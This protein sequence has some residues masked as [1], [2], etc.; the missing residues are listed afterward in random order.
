MALLTLQHMVYT[1]CVFYTSIDLK[2]W[3]RYSV[4]HRSPTVI[5]STDDEPYSREPS[6]DDKTPILNSQLLSRFNW[7]IKKGNNDLAK[8]SQT[9]PN[10]PSKPFWATSPTEHRYTFT[11]TCILRDLYFKRRLDITEV[12]AT[13][14][15]KLAIKIKWKL[16]RLASYFVFNL[17][18]HLQA[19]LRFKRWRRVEKNCEQ[20]KEWVI[21]SYRPWRSPIPMLTFSY[22]YSEIG[23]M[24]KNIYQLGFCDSLKRA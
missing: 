11:C 15:L 17:L 14:Y 19:T 16:I 13:P 6:Q 8:S 22:E 1:T 5:Y 12:T 2:D 9:L 18:T 24:S 10:C 20:K 4:W 23:L 7:G 21:P 3:I